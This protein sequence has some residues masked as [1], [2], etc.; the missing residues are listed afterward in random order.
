MANQA[1]VTCIAVCG[2]PR[3]GKSTLAKLL[4]EQQGVPVFCTDSLMGEPWA[5][6]PDRA[7]Q[8][9]LA[10]EHWILE[11]VQ[12]ARVLRRWLSDTRLAPKLRL[13]SVYWLDR[14]LVEQSDGQRSMAKGVATVFSSVRPLLAKAGVPILPWS[15][16]AQSYRPPAGALT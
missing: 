6:I 16:P 13:H 5:E 1:E 9:L 4:G 10:L 3:V 8:E 12:S 15:P 14:P 7:I 11:G 2:G